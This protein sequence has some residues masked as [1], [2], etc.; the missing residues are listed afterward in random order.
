MSDDAKGFY[1]IQLDN[2]WL[3]IIFAVFIV[4]LGLVFIWGMKVGRATAEL[5]KGIV[6]ENASETGEGSKIIEEDLTG[7]SGLDTSDDNPSLYDYKTDILK[8]DNSPETKP[9]DTNEIDLT[10]GGKNTSSQEKKTEKKPATTTRSTQEKPKQ[11]KRIP[12]GRPVT[13]PEAIN[14]NYVIQILSIRDKAKA[15]YFVK[16]LKDSGYKSFVSTVEFEDKGEMYRV[17]VGAFQTRDEAKNIVSQLLAD[18]RLK[19]LLEGKRNLMIY[20]IN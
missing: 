13:Q 14:G 1:E 6:S 17:R 5:E 18:S 7:E 11:E 15:E 8:N 20:K 2:K 19:Q 10:G 4:L 12:V 9:S 3:I 16:V